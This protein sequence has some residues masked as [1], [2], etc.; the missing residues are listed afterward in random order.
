MKLSNR[1]AGLWKT[2]GLAAVL[3]GSAACSDGVG[4][5]EIDADGDGYSVAQGDCNDA[6]PAIH[7]GATEIPN[8]GIDQDCDGIDGIDPKTLDQ[9]GDGFTPAD[10]DCDDGNARIYPGATEYCGDGVDQDCDGKDASCSTIDRD[11]DGVS[12]AQGDCDDDDPKVKPGAVEVPY[13]GKDDDCDP[14]TPDDDLDGDGFGKLSGGDCNDNDKTIFPGADEVPYDGIDQNC[15]GKDLVDVDG[16]GQAAV[17]AGGTDCDDTNPYVRLGGIEVCGDGVDQNCDGKDQA[18]S[19]QDLDGDGYSPAQGDCDDTDKNVHPFATEVP[20]N[21]KDEDCDPSTPDDDLDG[22]GFAKLGGGDCDDNNKL[23]FPGATEIPYDG[24]DQDCDG[25]DLVDLDG[26]GYA[27]T[28][29]AGGTDCDDNNPAIHPGAAEIPFDGIDQDC[30]GS[31]VPPGGSTVLTFSAAP[32]YLSVTASG[33]AYLAVW[34]SY[35]GTTHRVVG[36]RLDASLATLGTEVVLREAP[37][38]T[39]ID[40]LAIAPKSGGEW[41]CAWRERTGSNSAILTQ[42][43]SAQGAA[44]GSLQTVRPSAAG[45]VYLMSPGALAWDATGSRFAFTWRE[46]LSSFHTT[47]FTWLKAD[48]SVDGS[49]VTLSDPTQHSYEAT[50]A[51]ASTGAL[52]AWRADLQT[53]TYYDIY[54]RLVGSSGPGSVLTL[55]ALGHSESRPMVASDGSGFFVS[56]TSG[57]FVRG[58]RV[59]GSGAPVGSD[60]LIASSTTYLTPYDLTYCNGH[61]EQLLMDYRYHMDLPNL[62]HQA[63]SSTGQLQGTTAQENA[64]LFQGTTYLAYAQLA[65]Q[66]VKVTAFWRDQDGGGGQYRLAAQEVTP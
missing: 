45:D 42:V 64:L 59:D 1:V 28:K 10:G 2:I 46:Y 63:I 56:W 25:S 32:A 20:Y 8:D 11:G 18:C 44:K 9:D 27:S 5:H 66:G 23:I 43:I 35:D 26:D 16:D 57:G 65:C 40:Y 12:V 29:V 31:D 22:D 51:V 48:G 14:T 61:Y 30:D 54:A 50:V 55:A 53:G 13:N 38:G 41:L 7:P 34:R 21:G 58:R 60:V 15:D 49:P 24:I 33:S 4:L 6:N 47:R 36:Q 17:S 3:F 37:A 52:V 19:T 62:R 39:S